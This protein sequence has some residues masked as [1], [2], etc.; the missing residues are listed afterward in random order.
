MNV[1]K[2]NGMRT[3]LRQNILGYMLVLRLGYGLGYWLGY[4]LEF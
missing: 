2:L 1:A 3:I 4:A